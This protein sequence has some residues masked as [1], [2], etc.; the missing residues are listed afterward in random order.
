MLRGD[1]T[2]A[3]AGGGPRI[4]PTTSLQRHAARLTAAG[5]HA[6]GTAG[7]LTLLSPP[8]HLFVSAIGLPPRWPGPKGC[9][10]DQPTLPRSG[11][12]GVGANP[13]AMAPQFAAPGRASQIA[14][15]RSHGGCGGARV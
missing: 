13:R 4:A 3:R 10:G 15:Q 9:G 14:A 11:S 5:S 2:G 8:A 6:G 7:G 1:H 12:A